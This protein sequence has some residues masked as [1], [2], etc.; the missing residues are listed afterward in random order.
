[1]QMF[2]IEMI[3]M[4]IFNQEII[5][6]KPLFQSETKQVARVS[7]ISPKADVNISLYF[8]ISYKIWFD[9][10]NFCILTHGE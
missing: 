1:M 6:I 4:K 7:A 8:L 10:W 5:I 9:V 3:H 2:E